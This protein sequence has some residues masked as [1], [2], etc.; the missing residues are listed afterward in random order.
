MHKI[1]FC[2]RISR[3]GLKSGANVKEVHQMRHF[4]GW[5]IL[6]ESCMR[7]TRREM[8]E[9]LVGNTHLRKVDVDILM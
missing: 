2:V 8:N 3:R 1:L 7:T 5:T 9:G 6:D 4:K